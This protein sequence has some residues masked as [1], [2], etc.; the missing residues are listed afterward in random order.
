MIQIKNCGM[1][2]KAA[3]DAAISSGAGWLGFIHYPPSRRYV[4]FEDAAALC[5][6]SGAAAQTARR[7]AVLVNPDDDALDALLATGYATHIQLH[8]DEPPARIAAIRRRSGL[9]VIK[10]VGIAAAEDVLRAAACQ[11]SA[12]LLLLDTKH[13]AYGGTGEVFD[14]SLLSDA[15]FRLPW[16]LSG[17]LN[18]GNIETALRITGA[19]M[20][21][22]SSG[23][24]HE[25]GVKDPQR[26]RRFNETVLAYDG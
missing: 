11:D 4:P 14:W 8:G 21:D 25:K 1:R 12:D 7:V 15:D 3:I 10:A 16:F 5:S 17:G 6:G 19:Q 24:E 22:V 9:P 20:V 2:D 13:A 26:I 18:A 23:L